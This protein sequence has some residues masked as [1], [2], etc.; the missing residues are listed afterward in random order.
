MRSPSR[1]RRKRK[2]FTQ[3]KRSRCRFCK[4]GITDISYKDVH[5]LQKLITGRGLLMS[6]KR[7]GN[8]ASCQRKVKKAVK[9]ARFLGLFPY[10]E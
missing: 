7:S 8:C 4:D 5:R 3:R 1:S 6:R 9:Q 10:E 2:R